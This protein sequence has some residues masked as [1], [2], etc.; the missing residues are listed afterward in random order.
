MLAHLGM[1]GRF[2]LAS[3][4]TP[5]P[6]HLH[7]IFNL[8]DGKELRYIDPRRFGLILAMPQQSL[9]NHRLLRDLGPEPLKADFDG[10][11]LL[12]Q[13][14]MTSRPIKSLVMDAKVVVGIGNIYACEALFRAGIHPFRAAQRISPARI[15][16]LAEKIKEVLSQAIAK[17][18]TT[19]T[20]FLNPQGQAGYFRLELDVYGREQEDC[21]HCGRT[22]LRRVLSNRS[23]FYCPGCQR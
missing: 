18:G 5:K 13:T 22:I 23:T 9:K 4:G 11:Y 8:N 20:D 1:S 7:V 2:H 16:I 19:L 3:A 15:N 6:A 12:S 21:H 14:R 10:G 17:G